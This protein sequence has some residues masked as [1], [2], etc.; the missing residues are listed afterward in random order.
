MQLTGFELECLI[1]LQELDL[2]DFILTAHPGDHALLAAW[3][4]SL[5]RVNIRN[6]QVDY[7][8]SG[9]K[10]DR[11]LEDF[12]V[13][14]ARSTPTLRWLKSDLSDENIAMLKKERP[15]VTSVR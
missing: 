2:E 14:F 5:V 3:S 7:D 6:V 11:L 4:K 9:S 12:I 15:E 13:Q 10:N 1:G 8:L